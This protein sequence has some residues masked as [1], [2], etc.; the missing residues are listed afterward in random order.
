MWMEKPLLSDE[1]REKLRQ[2][3]ERY[4]LLVSIPTQ[5]FNPDEH[6]AGEC[7]VCLCTF[8]KGAKLKVF[9]CEGRHRFH[10]SCLRQWFQRQQQNCPVCRADAA[11]PPT[12]SQQ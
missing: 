7:T 3:Q 9:P 1:D 5:I 12:L 11:V 4:N 8:E 6:E 2:D 10:A